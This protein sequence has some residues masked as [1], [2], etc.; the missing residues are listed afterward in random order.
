MRTLRAVLAALRKGF[1][2]WQTLLVLLC[3]TLVCALIAVAPDLGVLWRFYSHAPLAE[4]RPLR[5]MELLFGMRQAF[6]P[7]DG[8]LR[9]LS[10]ARL[11]TSSVTL[12]VAL[13]LTL[14]ATGGVVWRAWTVDAFRLVDFTVESAR[15]FGRVVRT[16]LVSLPL[17]LACG[18]VAA[19]TGALLHAAHRDSVFTVPWTAW[20]L[21]RPL[22]SWA[23]A[24]LGLL[25]VL[26]ALWRL[27]LDASRVLVLVEELAQTHQAVWRAFWLVVRSPGA[28]AAYTLLGV[29]EVCTVLW[30][31]RLQAALPEGNTA[32]ALL[33][34]LVGQLVVVVRAGFQVSSTVFA[35]DLVRQARTLRASAALPSV[36]AAAAASVAP[37]VAAPEN[38]PFELLTAK[39]PPRTGSTSEMP[40]VDADL[41]D[42]E[43][44]GGG[45]PKR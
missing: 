41:I 43:P 13:S 45:P 42:E 40:L 5:S 3:V 20:L 6:P 38:E 19:A 18:A 34:L 37:D 29:A 14:L 44:G 32:L 23:V 12:L 10:L 30:V 15:M 16:L 8:P 17:L 27:T 11:G 1:S 22:G 7:G 4:G 9:P 28:W 31:M 26:F 39:E 35:A 33:A 36:A 24:H 21:E 25:A 2:D